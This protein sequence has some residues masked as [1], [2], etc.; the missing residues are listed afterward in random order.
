MR[1][2]KSGGKIYFVS[3]TFKLKRFKSQNIVRDNKYSPM[4]RFYN[5]F[6]YSIILQFFHV[7]NTHN[8]LEMIVQ[9]ALENCLVKINRLPILTAQILKQKFSTFIENLD[10]VWQI[11]PSEWIAEDRAMWFPINHWKFRIILLF[12]ISFLRVGSI[13]F[14]AF[15]NWEFGV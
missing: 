13:E 7:V 10:K 4:I 6:V 5:N 11:L 1:L 9:C 12:L 8:C 14:V 3:E 2:S 15:L